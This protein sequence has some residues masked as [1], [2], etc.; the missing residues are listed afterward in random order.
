MELA[1]RELTGYP[2]IWVE[3]HQSKSDGCEVLI[4][5]PERTITLLPETGSEALSMFYHPF[6]YGYVVHD[7]AEVTV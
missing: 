6:A 2:G 5:E 1:S 7:E 4:R 3:L